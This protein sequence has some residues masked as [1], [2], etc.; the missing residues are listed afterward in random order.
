MAR[1]RRQAFT[2]PR[3]FGF[4]LAG[5]QP[6]HS[7]GLP[8]ACDRI[9]RAPKVSPVR[10]ARSVTDVASAGLLGD[11][12][13]PPA[14]GAQGLPC[15]NTSGRARLFQRQ[16]SEGSRLRS[17][18]HTGHHGAAPHDRRNGATRRALVLPC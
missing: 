1:N 4:F 10:A 18:S 16:S 12:S 2:S 17:C 6:G 7:C 11:S 13:W 9:Q 15:D 5:L 14:C 8:A 3:T